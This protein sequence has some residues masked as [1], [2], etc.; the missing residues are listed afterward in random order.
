[1]LAPGIFLP[2]QKPKSLRTLT[3]NLAS[4]DESQGSAPEKAIG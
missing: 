2:Q 1:V 3:L 4:S